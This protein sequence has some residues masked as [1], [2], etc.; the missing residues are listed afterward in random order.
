MRF[1][2]F[3]PH[4]KLRPHTMTDQ[5]M[6]VPPDD[7]Q[8][9]G[10]AAAPALPTPRQIEYQDWE[11]GVFLHFGIRT[12]YEGHRDFDGQPMEPSAFYPANMNCNRWVETAK[13]AGARYM[14]LTAKHHDGFTLW[15]SRVSD[16]SVAAASWKG[17]KGDVIKE[18]VE[19]CRRYDMRCGIY[20]SPAEQTERFKTSDDEAYDHYILD[21]LGELLRGYG[22]IDI[23]WLD[24]CGSETHNYDWGRILGNVR[25]MQPNILVFN[26]GD[27]D[28]RWVGNEAGVA[29]ANLFNTVTH[30]PFSVRTG[31]EAEAG[32]GEPRWLPAECPCRMR[33]RNWFF[34]DRDEH[35]LKSLDE[36]MGIY[37]YSVGRGCNLLLNIGPDRRGLFPDKDSRRLL[38]F[39][40]T[41][42]KRFERPALTLKDFKPEK[43]RAVFETDESVLVDHAVIQEDLAK[44][45]RIRRFRIAVTPFPYGREEVTV[46]EGYSV[47]HKAICRFPL[48]RAKRIAFE[49]VESSGP[50]SLRSLD[51]YNTEKL[52]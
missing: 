28:I 5:P 9:T 37:Y 24:G 25:R 8:G 31:E 16:F 18:Y 29:P 22:E 48:V 17:G 26:M 12:F 50:V 35:T 36:L 46:Y 19:A 47:G 11:F 39:G 4:L 30:V 27:P 3:D 23:L 40:E 33:E 20:Y 2:I 14:V 34:S 49:I 6:P 1:S 13:R 52:R 43:N 21:Q 10:E 42:A 45:E 41:V 51:L 38:E 15:P 7:E 32:G 44:G